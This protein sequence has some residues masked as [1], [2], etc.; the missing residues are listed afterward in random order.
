MK[1]G[2]TLVEL[3][4][5]IAILAILVI[6][7]L[8]NVM[9]MFNTAKENSFT[10]EVKEVFKT[11]EQTWI[12][13][14]MFNSG[15]RIY[16]RCKN[17]CTNS[18][19]LTGRS[20]LEYYIKLNQSG[21]IT[22][23]YATD[24][25]FQYSYDGTGLKIENI[26]DIQRVS[27][28]DEDEKVKIDGNGPYI[29]K[30]TIKYKLVTDRGSFSTSGDVK[31]VYINGIDDGYKYDAYTIHTT[32]LLNSGNN[33]QLAIRVN[34]AKSNC[35]TDSS[36]YRIYWIY[37][38]NHD[39]KFELK[40]SDLAEHRYDLTKNKY[41]DTDYR[42][43]TYLNAG[44]GYNRAVIRAEMSD[45]IRNCGLVENEFFYADSFSVNESFTGPW[46]DNNT[47]QTYIDTLNNSVSDYYVSGVSICNN[48]SENTLNIQWTKIEDVNVC[49][50]STL[51]YIN[52]K[53]VTSNVTCKN[54]Q[55]AGECFKNNSNYNTKEKFYI[56]DKP[57]SD[58]NNGNNS[59]YCL[60]QHKLSYQDVYISDLV[61]DSSNG[62]YSHATF[63]TCLSGDMEID[64][65][66][67]K[68]K[69][70]VKKKLKD[71]TYDDLVLSWDFDKGCYVWAEVLWI[72]KEEKS[73]NYLLLTFSDGSTLKVI[74][75][76]RIFSCDDNSF[77][78]CSKMKIGTTTINSKGEVISLIDSKI[79]YEEVD[80][81]NIITKNHINV[82]ANGLLTSRGRNNLYPIENMRFVKE[83]GD[84][85]NRDDFPEIS[86][87]YFYGLRIGDSIRNYRG[88]EKLT[89]DNLVLLVQR[90]EKTKKKM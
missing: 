44:F 13:D 27:E 84:R 29:G 35:F 77:I 85:F 20:E 52:V 83:N 14:S 25:T 19:D 64:V 58:C 50:F 51:S 90:L 33:R 45:D 23:Y 18:L 62:C 26:T 7:A 10:T 76:H 34:L 8:P 60:N 17:G 39:L 2:F 86:D 53:G 22:K 72:M 70:K 68:K 5:V 89:R 80:V 57:S 41:L 63:V 46:V 54:Y 9:N 3:L 69:K 30:P 4:A 37:Q 49:Y 73:S 36:Y 48:C 78:S 40:K 32:D 38:G 66:D 43:T 87:E 12:Q 81:C 55:T 61:K 1:K 82:F 79:V 71:I 88:N 42:K 47:F 28:L 59:I 56:Y 65:Y 67:R 31:S 15:E 74:G 11:A 24:R 16:S 6:I 21:K 75:D